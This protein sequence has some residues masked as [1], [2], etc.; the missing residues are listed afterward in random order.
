MSSKTHTNWPAII[1]GVILLL[2][3]G[4]AGLL[5]YGYTLKGPVLVAGD[6]PL[7]KTR[8]ERVARF[9]ADGLVTP[10]R[11][12]RGEV[13]AALG[14]PITETAVELPNASDERKRD[15][16][17]KMIYAGAY[18]EVYHRGDPPLDQV[19][20]LTVDSRRHLVRWGLDIGA[21]A[22]RVLRTLGPPSERG[23]D[24]LRYAPHPTRYVIFRLV[25]GK[26]ASIEW[27]H[28]L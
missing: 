8:A 25:R 14:M 7:P 18:V 24:H 15:T 21:P 1:L 27:Y 19:I 22:A 4:T 26:V 23:P 2:L 5:I 28:F 3:A 17:T 13:I 10:V 12:S 20:R 9:A 6:I 16:L 11:G